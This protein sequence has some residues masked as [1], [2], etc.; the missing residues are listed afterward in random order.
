MRRLLSATL[1]MTTLSTVSCS[2]GATSSTPTPAVQTSQIAQTAKLQFAVGTATIQSSGGTVYGTNFVSTFRGSSGHSATLVNTPT[3]TG[4][5]SFVIGFPGTPN[6]IAGV[7]PNVFNTAVLNASAQNDY[8]LPKSFGAGLGPFVGVFGYGMAADNLV[9]AQVATKFSGPIMSNGGLCQNLAVLSSEFVETSAAVYTSL[10]FGT[11]SAQ[12]SANAQSAELGNPVGSGNSYNP[13]VAG[14][15]VNAC[16]AS[17]QP[18][19]ESGD[20][21]L[22][23]NYYGGPPAWPSPQGYGNPLFFVGFPV[24]FTDFAATPVAGKYSLDVAYPTNNTSTT[25]GHFDATATLANTQALPPLAITSATHNSDGTGSVVLTV[26]TGLFETIVFLRSADCDSTERTNAARDN[27][28]IVTHSSGTQKLTFAANLGPPNN[29]GQ[30]VPTFCQSV[31]GGVDAVAFAVGF[32]YPAYESSY[33]FDLTQTP[34]I[35]NG[36]G[37]SG[38]ADITTTLPFPL[39]AGP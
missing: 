30:P 26:P 35:T 24:G 3:I 27:Y 6:T 20:A 36:D 29:A 11:N 15:G 28:A 38:Q 23:I 2:N 9:S 12:L 8:G 22:P 33:P 18:A 37:H 10:A 5:P 1:L 19:V 39:T 7:L 13:D 21:N 25:Y 4:P 14:A 32:D 34:K 17:L 16:P 31:D